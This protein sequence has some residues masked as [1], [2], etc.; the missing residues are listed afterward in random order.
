[1]TKI[2]KEDE[3]GSSS[4]VHADPEP[5]PFPDG[6]LE[7]WIV[8]LGAWCAILPSFGL[9]NTTGVFAD[10][11]TTH[12]LRAYSESEVSWIFSVHIFFLLVGGIQIGR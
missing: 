1:M 5:Q 3:V 10:W 8:V 11:L 6:G 2:T 9:M 12:Q 7:A 4:S